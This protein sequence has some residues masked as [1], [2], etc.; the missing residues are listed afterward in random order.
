MSG[1]VDGT[2]KFYAGDLVVGI[3]GDGDGSGTYTDNQATPITLEEITTTGSIVGTMVL[4]QTTTIVNGTTEYAISG[5]YGSSSEGYLQ[6]SADGQSLVIGGYGVNAATYNDGGAAVYGNAALAQSTS[7]IGTQYTPVARVI[8]DISYTGTVDT[9][10]ALYNVFDTNNI[11]SVATVDGTSFYVGGQG[12]KGD[13]TQGVFYAQDGANTATAINTA[14]D[15]RDVQI[16]NGALYVSTDSKQGSGGTSN[17]SLYATLPTSAA[18][19]TVLPGIDGSITLTAGEE[20]GINNADVGSAVNL[21]PEGYFFADATTLYI[22]DGGTP[23][24]GGVGDGGLQKWS[25]A[26]GSWH[27]D[28]TLAAGLDLV[29]NTASAGTTGLIGLSGTVVGGEVYLYA[30]NETVGDLDQKYVYAIADTLSA[31]TLPT[32]ESFTAIVTAAADT[33]IRGISFAPTSSSETTPTLVVSSGAVVSET[34]T[35]GSTVMVESGGTLSASTILSGGQVVVSAGGLDSG[36]TIAHGATETLLGSASNDVVQ[37]TQLISGAGATATSETVYNGGAIDLFLKGGVVNDITLTNGGVLAISGNAVANDTTIL[38]GGT[39]I[40]ESAKANMAGSLVFSGAGVLEETAA[41][42]A[43]YGVSAVI[44]GFGTDDAVDLATFGTGA[45]LTS[46]V[47]SGN[48]VE[49]VTSGGVSETFTFAGLV[50]GLVLSADGSG[51]AEI[52]LGAAVVSSGGTLVVSSGVTSSG[53]SV[54]SGA[55]LEVQNGGTLVG[56]TVLSGGTVIDSGFDSGSVISFGGSE[57]VLGAASGDQIYGTQIVS[58]ANAVVNGETVH[59]GG[60][61]DLFLKTTSAVGTVVE[62]GGALAISGN[63]VVSNIVLDGG[64]LLETQSPKANVE[65]A[66]VF[67]GG[68]TIAEYDIISAGHGIVATISGWQGGDVIDTTYQYADAS[69]SVVSSGGMTEVTLSVTSADPAVADGGL[70]SQTFTFAGDYAA[71]AFVLTSGTSGEAE[72]VAP[73]F[74]TGTL[75][76]TETGE[77]AVEDLAIGDCVVTVTGESR[78]IRWIGH[79]H[80]TVSRH[81]QPE[82]V[83]PVRV[84]AHAFGPNLPARDLILSPDHAL[85]AEGVLVPVK[86]LIGAGGIAPLAME[87]V[88]YWHVELDHHEVI[89]AEGLPAE[90]YLDTGDRRAFANAEGTM[91]L[92]PAWGSARADIT[93]IMESLGYAPLQVAGTEVTRIRAMLD[94]VVTSA[95]A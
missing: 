34:V 56:A 60:V 39:V 15:V 63:A 16:L 8:A 4:A 7:L 69:L 87:R 84:P 55:V 77:V 31:T 13:T 68:A 74:A 28:Y 91:T 3:V 36:S 33:N 58:A 19:G 10:T 42:S 85:F 26:D 44:S 12:V 90:S 40:L 75:I 66:I 21:S 51:G 27:L 92:H 14:T 93:L 78:A 43:G 83:R 2:L 47:V 54:G 5:E 1:T 64:A 35:S 24:E 30:T 80:V 37:G 72:I 45:T 23:K 6:L 25:F 9:S 94:G 65:G 81:A 18:T 17:I 32:D 73:C 82:D 71:A 53:L 67:S 29:A 46:A 70:A 88:T 79:R 11:R 38:S 41:V 48:T 22:A 86:H 62:S 50:S 57:T 49:T 20:N 61:L 89:L 95:A 59:G 52:V 76:R